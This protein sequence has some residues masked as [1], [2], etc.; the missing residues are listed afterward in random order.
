VDRFCLNP[1]VR[2][3]PKVGRSEL[4]TEVRSSKFAK[5]CCPRKG[6]NFCQYIQQL[7]VVL[8]LMRPVHWMNV[9]QLLDESVSLPVV[10]YYFDRIRKGG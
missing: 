5:L 10:S 8:L 4:R 7:I 2:F 6:T 9:V 1:P 3:K